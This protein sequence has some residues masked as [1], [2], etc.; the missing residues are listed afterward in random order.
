[1]TFSTGFTSTANDGGNA[2][3]AAEVG[4]EMQKKLSITSTM[5]GSEVQGKTLIITLKDFQAP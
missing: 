3:R 4:R 1:M 2:E 5:H